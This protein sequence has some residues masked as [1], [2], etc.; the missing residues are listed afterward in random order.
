MYFYALIDSVILLL[1]CCTVCTALLFSYSAIFIAASVRNKLIH[2]FI[3]SSN[4]AHDVPWQA[5]LF[6]AWN[7][8]W[9]RWHL[10][11]TSRD[12]TTPSQPH[13][14]SP[15]ISA[16]N[17]LIDFIHSCLSCAHTQA[18]ISYWPLIALISLEAIRYLKPR[19]KQQCCHLATGV[20]GSRR[21]SYFVF[22]LYC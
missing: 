22:V 14:S 10:C 3:D 6:A 12:M 5:R 7:R 11:L 8:P 16:F 2:S 17:F 21:P 18:N 1:F 15:G 20:A 9:T 4:Q 19:P 13:V